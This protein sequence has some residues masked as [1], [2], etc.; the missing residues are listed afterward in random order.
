MVILLSG[1]GSNALNILDAIEAGRVPMTLVGAIADRPAEGLDRL[2]ER[3]IDT[4]E[5]PRPAF[6][7]RAA[8]EQALDEA[9]TGFEPDLVALAGFMRVLSNGFVERHAGQMINIHP[10]LLPAY[11]GLDTH[12][13]ALADRVTEHGASVHWVTPELDG[14]PVIAQARVP[15]APGD[16]VDALTARVLEQEHRLY[17]AVLALLGRGAVGPSDDATSTPPLVLDR[18][19]DADGRRRDP[20]RAAPA[21]RSG[22]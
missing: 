22:G 6:P 2:A 4:V 11:R 5:I 15:V 13:R 17:P 18:D 1:R 14:G 3:G 8:F 7:D 20:G 12:A 10:S 19:L 16:D 9:L 21:P